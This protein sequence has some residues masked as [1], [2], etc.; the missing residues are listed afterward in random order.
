MANKNFTVAK[1]LN[2]NEPISPKILKYIKQ[3]EFIIFLK[4][5]KPNNLYIWRFNDNSGSPDCLEFEAEISALGQWDNWLLVGDSDGFVTV[6]EV[7]TLFGESAIIPILLDGSPVVKFC[8][9]YILTKLG[10]WFRLDQDLVKKLKVSKIEFDS[11]VKDLVKFDSL[12]SWPLESLS[13]TPPSETLLTIGKDPCIA[14]YR[15]EQGLNLGKLAIAA[16]GLFKVN[17]EKPSALESITM[18][19][20][21]KLDDSGRSLEYLWSCQNFVAAVDNNRAQV[22]IVDPKHMIITHIFKGYRD[23]ICWNDSND[24]LF[25]ASNKRKILAKWSS[26]FENLCKISFASDEL[27]V[28]S[29]EDGKLLLLKRDSVL[30]IVNC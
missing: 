17:S 12:L 24:C 5:T 2:V 1:E 28:S 19:I 3:E 30:Q 14:F 22:L 29:L 21:E 20:V 7:Y 26:S 25:L 8:D 6:L 4:L 16:L 18:A 23:V 27:I 11:H 10:R 15:E 9:N 13:L